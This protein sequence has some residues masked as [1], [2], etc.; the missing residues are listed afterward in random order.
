LMGT[1]AF[2][3]MARASKSFLTETLWI[4]HGGKHFLH[5]A[6]RQC[7]V[8]SICIISIEFN[9]AQIAELYYE[10]VSPVL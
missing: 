8:S 2:L 10:V 4:C 9:N 5:L 3:L 7:A 6:E 1:T